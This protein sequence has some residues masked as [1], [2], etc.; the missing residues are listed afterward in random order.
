MSVTWITV[1]VLMVLV[2]AAVCVWEWE[3]VPVFVCLFSTFL[4]AAVK[5]STPFS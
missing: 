2:V 5:L 3:V 1:V 4:F